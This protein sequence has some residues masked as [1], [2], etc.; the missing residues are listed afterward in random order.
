VC[1]FWPADGR[2]FFVFFP[3]RGCNPPT[4]VRVPVG[5]GQPFFKT[6]PYLP[7]CPGPNAFGPVKNPYPPRSPKNQ[8]QQ[9]GAHY[10]LWSHLLSPGRRTEQ[11]TRGRPSAPSWR[12]QGLKR[13]RKLSSPIF[14]RK[15]TSP[16]TSCCS[17]RSSIF[18]RDGPS[19]FIITNH[20]AP[21]FL[22][23]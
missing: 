6:P 1:H 7:G 17:P 15:M 13:K 11:Q 5:P 10:N 3:L 19:G 14:P 2:E 18:R 16:A 9:H 22:I 20:N 8:G 21:R 12:G 4:L 23:P